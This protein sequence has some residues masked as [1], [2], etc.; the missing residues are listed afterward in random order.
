M[1]S[2]TELVERLRRGDVKAFDLV[3]MK[4]AGRLYSFSM[5]YLKSAEE[6]EELVQNVFL[7]L[8]EKQKSLEQDKSFKSYLFTIAYNEICNQFRKR[9]HLKEF[10]R[11]SLQQLQEASNETEE[12]IDSEF[13]AQ[14]VEQ[15]IAQ[16]PPKLKTT[17]LLSRK[18][19]KSTREIAAE[20]GLSP[21]T[22]DNYLSES[23]KIIRQIL[24]K[25]HIA[26]SLY[27]TLFFL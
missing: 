3:Y 6:A 1:I 14:R 10:V 15:I 2:D 8:W 20:L 22:V 7:K 17:F 12:N 18:E 9:S 13:F 5:K 19:G 25:E 24:Q 26:L 11:E 16:L 23:I 21:G 27:I 4:Y